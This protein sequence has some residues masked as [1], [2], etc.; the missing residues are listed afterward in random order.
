VTDE[1]REYLDLIM[2]A[3]LAPTLGERMRRLVI[4]EM[5]K[6]Q[7]ILKGVGTW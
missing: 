1:E 5:F 2:E 6:P 3:Y 4:A 7:P